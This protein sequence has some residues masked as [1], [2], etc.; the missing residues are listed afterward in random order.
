MIQWQF[1]LLPALIILVIPA[2]I[3]IGSFW[4]KDTL[5]VVAVGAFLTTLALGVIG[6]TGTLADAIMNPASPL[7]L[8][9]ILIL[10]G[11]AIVAFLLM[12]AGWALAL[13]GAAQKRHWLWLI[14]LILGVYL[15]L[16][17]FLSIASMSPNFY[18]LA[19]SEQLPYGS[20]IC[21]EPAPSLDALYLAACLLGPGS[22]L[23]Y[24][25]CAFLARRGLRIR[26]RSLPEGLSLSTLNARQTNDGE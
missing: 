13:A 9:A 18:C 19:A 16:V 1:E 14:A 17:L 3:L 2:T 20:L 23:V 26:N 12:S 22:I 21:S 7:D 10:I 24:A 15:S 6:M 11:L 25:I 8:R 5:I 4:F